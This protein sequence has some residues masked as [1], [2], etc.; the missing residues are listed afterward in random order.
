VIGLLRAE[1]LRAWSRRFVRVLAI[2]VGASIVVSLAIG[3]YNVSRHSGD[4][5]YRAAL[6][7]CLSGNLVPE[8]KLPPSYHGDLAAYCADQVRPEY[9]GVSQWRWA[10]LP[11][12][13]TSG[14]SSMVVLL[15]VLLG[16]SLSGADWT[17]G[18]MGTLLTWEPRRTRVHLTRVLVTT[19]AVL[20]FTLATQLWLIGVFRIAIAIS[21]TT[22]GTPPGTTRHLLEIIVRVAVVAAAFG[23]VAHAVATFGRSTVAAVGVL[24]GYLI[25]VEAFLAGLWTAIQ[26]RLLIRAAEVVISQQPLLGRASVTEGPNGNVIVQSQ[27]VLLSVRGAWVVLAVWVVALTALALLVFRARD[28]S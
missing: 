3:S 5:A 10:D 4:A 18:T 15:G 1:L 21:G 9:Y 28:V 26:P 8:N 11:D 23:L 19:V 2:A 17:A 14:T 24:F 12:A 25:V 6:Q 16:A 27:A 22:A 7:D 20:V 13:L